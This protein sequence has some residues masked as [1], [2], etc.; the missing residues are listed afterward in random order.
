MGGWEH[1][2]QQEARRVGSRFLAACN[3]SR[4]TRQLYDV[5]HHARYRVPR[6]GRSSTRYPPT[7]TG[8][9]NGLVFRAA[10]KEL[11]TTKARQKH[12]IPLGHATTAMLRLPC[13]SGLSCYG[14]G[15]CYNCHVTATMLRWVVM[16]RRCA[17]LRLRVTRL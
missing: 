10:P 7:E 2:E 11:C 13:Y 3:T 16:L 14:A 9:K 6:T 4:A 1:R 8:E 15:P 12:K 17:M 5:P